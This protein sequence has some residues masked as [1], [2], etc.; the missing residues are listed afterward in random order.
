MLILASASP[1]RREL[2]DQIGLE[3]RVI[4]STVDES[5]F[6]S[7]YPADLVRDLA[8]A[9]AKQVAAANPGAL[10]LGADTVVVVDGEVLGK[11]SGPQDAVAMLERL[12][13]REHQVFT[14]IALVKDGAQTAQHE[15]TAVT[16]RALTRP[17]IE[18]YVASGE[19]LD[20]AG[21]Y[22]IQGRGAA[23]IDSI[24]GEYTS[25]VGLPLPKLVRMLEGFGINHL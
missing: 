11:P 25:V 18:R 14:G 16:M 9:K 12:Q 6:A 20:K 15:M 4:A 24:S 7:P 2:L 1:R 21:A 5:A 10:V 13:G 8:L 19:P 22:A 23:L 3:Y 17:Q